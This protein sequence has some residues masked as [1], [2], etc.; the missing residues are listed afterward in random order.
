MS[1]RDSIMRHSTHIIQGTFLIIALLVTIVPA[2]VAFAS[3][4]R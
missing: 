1:I 4:R 3:R 2:V